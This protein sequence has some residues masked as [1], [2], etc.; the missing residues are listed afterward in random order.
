MNSTS[1][2]GNRGN[3]ELIV[4][5]VTAA[6]ILAGIYLVMVELRQAR[7]ISTV[8]MIHTRLVANVEHDSRIF[9]E[10]LAV[11]LAKA[12]HNPNDLDDSE[13]IALNYYFLTR[14]RQVYIVYTGATLGTYQQGIGI[15]ENWRQLGTG[16]I[17]DILAYPSG[18][19]W[20][21]QHPYYQNVANAEKDEVVGLVQ[22]LSE[23]SSLL[24]CS[25]MRDVLTP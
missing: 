16:Y 21:K 6:S 25:D 18:R 2:S 19:H 23:T 7:E 3:L 12:C 10:N 9:G 8:Q 17:R 5:L 24:D 15:V 1:P 14:V 22:S 13:V 4:Q 11:T 20:I